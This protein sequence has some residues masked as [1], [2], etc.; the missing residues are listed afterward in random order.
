MSKLSK[1]IVRT[2]ARARDRIAHRRR[3]CVVDVLGYQLPGGG[4][5]LFAIKRAIFHEPSGWRFRMNRCLPACSNRSCPSVRP[6]GALVC[7]LSLPHPGCSTS[8]GAC[9]MLLA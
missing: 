4:R 8:D 2:F 9:R 6:T 7:Q 5:S 3:K 1:T